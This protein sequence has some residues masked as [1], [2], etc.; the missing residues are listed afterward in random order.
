MAAR[1][2][3]G[4][5][6]PA[7]RYPAHV[8]RA[9]RDADADDQEAEDQDSGEAEDQPLGQAPRTMLIPPGVL[10]AAALVLGLTPAL[11]AALDKAAFDFVDRPAYAARILGLPIPA[12][13]PPSTHLAGFSFGTICVSL[14]SVVLA[15]T[16]A[17]V[18]L[19]RERVP[20]WTA[21]VLRPAVAILGGLRA[22][23]TGHVGDYVTWLLVGVVVLGAALTVTSR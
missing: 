6:A 13:H 20:E 21:K 23:H 19:G 18:A 5:G 7:A 17:A 2:F 12:A 8:R 15:L 10:L 3:L 14:L 4:L 9:D 16:I 22:L 1:I 11:P